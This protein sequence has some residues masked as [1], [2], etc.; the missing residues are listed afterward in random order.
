MSVSPRPTGSLRAAVKRWPAA[1]VRYR[2]AIVAAWVVLA[3][4]LIPMARNLEGRLE[5]S[6]RMPSGQAEAVRADLE[7]RFRSPF[8]Y[9]VLLVAEGIPNPGV[10]AGRAA[11]ERIVG[12][13]RNTHG[14]AG[15][16]SSI[17]TQDPLFRGREDGFLVIVG[18]DA[19]PLPVETLLPVLRATTDALTRELRRTHPQAWLGWTGEAPLNFDLRIASTQDARSAELRVLPFTLLLLLLAFGSVVAAILP[20]GVGIL[21]IALS[22]GVAAYVAQYF[23]LSVLIQSLASMIGLGLGIDYA[24]LT[25][26]RFREA[27]AAGRD[28]RA[29]A[30]E[31]TR[32]A[33]WTILLSAFP[34]SISFAALLT[35]PL[36]ELRSVG[37]AGLTVTVFALLLS[38]TLLP[39]VLATLG[40][41]VD[42]LRVRPRRRTYRAVGSGAWRRWAHGV[43]ARPV[44]SLVLASA[45]LFCSR[46]RRCGSTRRCPAA[47]GCRRD[48]SPCAP[49]TGWRRWGAST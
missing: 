5:V 33:G 45:P 22:L 11:L 17:D 35:I 49:T 44:V 20:I 30:E 34:V 12:A 36:S 43:I 28:T 46:R 14:V 3:A 27:L 4:F 10:P 40:P 31:A 16:L 23:T 42:S 39:A 8:T 2:W 41:H 25:V 1:V 37:F 15:T 29:A 48:P 21:S 19:G 47:T 9:R 24:L 38:V 6:A 7:Q 26:S 13:L 32:H 18:L